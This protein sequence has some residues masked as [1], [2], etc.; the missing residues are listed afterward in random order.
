MAAF[1]GKHR[2]MYSVAPIFRTP[3]FALSTYRDRPAIAG[4]PDRARS[5]AA[6]SVMIGEA[7]GPLETPPCLIP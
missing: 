1:I 6:V 4:D 5:D 2:E 3:Q 7:W